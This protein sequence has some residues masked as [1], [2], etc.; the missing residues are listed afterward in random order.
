MTKEE[1][2]TLLFEV[3]QG[4]VIQAK[5]RAEH[6]MAMQAVRAEDCEI[7][8]STAILEAGKPTGYND[9]KRNIE[10]LVSRFG[11]NKVK[12]ILD[13]MEVSK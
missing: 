12:A 3:L 5:A 4:D 8:V 10:L 2:R 13:D 6:K 11:L 1:M 9:L 7:H